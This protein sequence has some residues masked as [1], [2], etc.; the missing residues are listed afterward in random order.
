MAVDF[1][2][3]LRIMTRLGDGLTQNLPQ[4]FDLPLNDVWC[5]IFQKNVEKISVFLYCVIQGDS[6]LSHV[7]GRENG[8][9]VSALGR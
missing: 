3:F 4:K 9:G 5:K 8:G 7:F 1:M 2:F 6:C